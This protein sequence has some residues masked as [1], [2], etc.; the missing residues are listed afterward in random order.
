M[1]NLVDTIGVVASIILPLF[2]IPLITRV[3]KRKSSQDIS[4]T[5]VLGVWV[6]F[7]LMLPSGIKS[8]DIVWR[9][10]NYANITMFTAVVFVSLK[11]HKGSESDGS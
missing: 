4:L 8:D 11:Y 9:V 2:N 10:F 7:L 6:C 5:W 1:E 3:I